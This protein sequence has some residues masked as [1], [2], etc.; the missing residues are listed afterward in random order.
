MILLVFTQ[1]AANT[2]T[3]ALF[4]TTVVNKY[5]FISATEFLLR[6]D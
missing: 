6:D 3:S 4:T 1:I 5:I 2:R